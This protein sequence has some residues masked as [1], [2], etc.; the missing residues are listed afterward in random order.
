MLE[1]LPFVQTDPAP[2]TGI[3]SW[4][5]REQKLKFNQALATARGLMARQD[6]QALCLECGSASS[7]SSQDTNLNLFDLLKSYASSPAPR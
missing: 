2:I 3:F 4:V 6:V 5:A 7:A 1:G